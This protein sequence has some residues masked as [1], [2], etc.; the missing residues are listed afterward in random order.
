MDTP[1]VEEDPWSLNGKYTKLLKQQKYMTVYFVK[2]KST[3]IDTHTI[4]KH[5]GW[6]YDA[7]NIYDEELDAKDGKFSDD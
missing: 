1:I 4:M 7:S 2:D 6:G 5:S 3:L